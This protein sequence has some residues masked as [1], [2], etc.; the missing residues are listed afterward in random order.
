MNKK[1]EITN[2]SIIFN[3]SAAYAKNEAEV[4]SSDAFRDILT[5]Y[6]NHLE[7]IENSNLLKVIHLVSDPVK[8][9]TNVFKLLLS[10]DIDEIKTVNKEFDLILENK[11]TLYE[12]V[13]NF[14]NY[15]RR[16]E[17]YAVVKSPQERHTIE[18]VNFIAETETF[19]QLILK[20]YRAIA[21]KLQGVD[22]YIYRQLTAGVNASLSICTNKWAS[23]SSIYSKLNN[24][25]FFYNLLYLICHKNT[26]H[27]P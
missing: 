18:S 20:T 7:E 8:V 26:L 5:R 13:E 10:F 21:Q 9:L 11:D 16:L 6:I 17:R 24:I 4:L 14:Y 25:S 19:N 12:L 3:F 2:R 22:F 27:L 23:E 15:W 1:Y